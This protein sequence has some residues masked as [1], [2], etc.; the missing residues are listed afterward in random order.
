MPASSVSGLVSTSAYFIAVLLLMV[1]VMTPVAGLYRDASAS[2][3]GALAR[4]VADQIDAMSPGM[5]TELE[6]AAYPGTSASVA[7]SGSTVTATVNGFSSTQT[8]DWP[9]AA[10][11]LESG[12][13]YDLVISGGVV[14]VE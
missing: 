9:L 4:G 7:L 10:A 3:A 6:L 8:V 2:S 11:S 13:Q 12:H 14:T 5:K 1:V